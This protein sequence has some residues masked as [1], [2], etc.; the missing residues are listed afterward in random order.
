MFLLWCDNCKHFHDQNIEIPNTET[1]VADVYCEDCLPEKYKEAYKKS[2]EE[3][4]EGD[5]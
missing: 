4:K 2:K 1:G 3:S 5:E